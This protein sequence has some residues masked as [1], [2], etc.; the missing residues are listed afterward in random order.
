MS[1]ATNNGGK[2]TASTDEKID[3]TQSDEKT[4]LIKALKGVNHTHAG[5]TCKPDDVIRVNAL[6]AIRLTQGADAKWIYAPDGEKQTIALAKVD[7]NRS[8]TK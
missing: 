3:L 4:R 6:A 8:R 5:E 1:K 7:G 2:N